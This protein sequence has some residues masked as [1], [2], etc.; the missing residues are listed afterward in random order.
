MELAYIACALLLVAVWLNDNALYG[1]QIETVVCAVLVGAIAGRAAGMRPLP[2]DAG[3]PEAARDA[4]PGLP[5]IGV[6]PPAREMT[7]AAR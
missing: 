7:G 3:E 4:G 1:G 6:L 5:P 2:A